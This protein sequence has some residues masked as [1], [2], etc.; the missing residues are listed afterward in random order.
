M[1]D[2]LYDHEI[3]AMQPIGGIS[4]YYVELLPRLREHGVAVDLFRGLHINRF[5][6]AR[7][8]LARSWGVRRPPR[9][10]TRLA[11]PINRWLFARHA[12]RHVPQIYHST[13]YADDLPPALGG[14]LRVVTV[15]DLIDTRL[16]KTHVGSIWST[17]TA[18]ARHVDGWICI[19][20]Q[21]RRDLIDIYKVDPARTCVIHHA[22]DLAVPPDARPPIDRPYVLQVGGRGGYKNLDV[23]LRAFKASPRLA[24]EVDLVCFGHPIDAAERAAWDAGE[25]RI[26]SLGGDD[27]AL[28]AAYAGARAFIYPSLYEGFGMPLLEAMRCDCPVAASNASCFPEIAADAAEYFDPTDAASA[29]RALESIVFDDARRAELI[30]RGRARKLAF[31]WDRAAVETSAFYRQTLAAGRA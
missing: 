17:S 1:I 12:R 27:R 8:R 29:A 19:S 10:T 16:G 18:A 3:F 5:P 22:S 11:A 21:T 30:V 13:S 20:E 25:V 7:D 28:A 26:H 31:S 4:R 24:R 9:H 2:V 14:V 6:L 23:V 15:H